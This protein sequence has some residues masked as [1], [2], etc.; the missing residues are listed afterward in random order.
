VLWKKANAY[1][2]MHIVCIDETCLFRGR[3]KMKKLIA[4]FALVAFIAVGLALADNATPPLK[5]E[6]EY[7]FVGAPIDGFVGAPID[8][9]LFTWAGPVSGDV[10]GIIIW[11]LTS[12]SPHPVR[13]PNGTAQAGQMSFKWEIWDEEWTPD[14]MESWDGTAWEDWYNGERVL[15]LAGDENERTIVRHGKNSVW[16]ANG[17][18]TEASAEYEDYIGSQMHDGG[19]FTWAASGAPD[20]GFGKLRIAGSHSKAAPGRH[21]TSATSWGNI[22][23]GQ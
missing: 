2:L 23:S 20:H 6:T 3:N 15:S 17:I 16:R 9:T 21:S 18:V 13:P 7:F 14:N 4:V 5:C 8:A 19:N 1:Q 12:V 10:D 11:W 22:K